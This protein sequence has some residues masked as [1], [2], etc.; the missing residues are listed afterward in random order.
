[1]GVKHEIVLIVGARPNFMKAAPL[2]AALHAKPDLSVRLIHTG[3]HFDKKMSLVFFQQLN[4]AHPD[5]YLDVN[6]GSQNQQIAQVMLKLEAIFQLKRPDWVVVFGDVSSTVAAALTANKMG[7][8]LAHVEAG[9]RSF[10]RSMP[11]EHNRIVADMLSDWLFTPSPDAD[12]NLLREGVPAKRIFQVGNIMVDSLTKFK[13]VAETL[14][15]WEG[16]GFNA[17]SYGLITLHRPGNVDNEVVLRGLVEALIEIQKS[18]PLLFPIHPRTRTKLQA[19]GWLKRLEDAGIK[20]SEPAGYLEF[21]SLMTQAKF[22]L[23]DSG[24]IQEET[25]MLGIPCLT[26]RPNT[27]RPITISE[28]TNH[29]VG[30]NAEGI[31]RG[32]AHVLGHRGKPGRPKLWDGKTAERIADIVI[33]KLNS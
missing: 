10:D 13:P 7:I 21:L 12:E 9:L 28:G 31:L 20:L 24:G 16:F 4:L 5:S 22:V 2:F 11:E 15:A 27:E 8:T 19:N 3:Q 6:G 29:L 1:M 30:N 23:T 33:Q 32:Y 14:R 17:Q 26:A 18:T 25:T